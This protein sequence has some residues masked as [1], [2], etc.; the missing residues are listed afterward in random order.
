MTYRLAPGTLVREE[1]FGLLFY[2]VAGPKLY[3]LS[4]GDLLRPSFFDGELTLDQW[5]RL[6]GNGAHVTM[7]RMEPVRRALEQLRD[8]GV[9]IEC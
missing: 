5:A 3:F 7:N 4:C 8:K 2:T 6:K 1:E 9:V